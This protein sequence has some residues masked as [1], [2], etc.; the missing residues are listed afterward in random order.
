VCG[1]GRFGREVH[2]YLDYEGIRTTVIEPNPQ[3]APEGTIIGRGTEAVTLREADIDKAVGLVAGADQ[4]INN[5]S[6]IMTAKELKPDLFIVARQNRRAN[7]AIFKAAKLDLIMESS[8]ILVWRILPLLTNPLLSRF[9]LEARHRNEAWARELLQQLRGLCQG[10]TPQTWSIT[11]DPQQM[12]ALSAMLAQ[13]QSLLLRDLI[14]DPGARDQTLPCLALMRLRAD[15]ETLL[16][17][18]ESTLQSGDQ[19]LFCGA[20]QAYERQQRALDNPQLLAFLMTGQEQPDSYVWRWLS[21]QRK[22][23]VRTTGSIQ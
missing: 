15:K 19:I 18:P 23:S 5:L 10:R 21:Q 11:L 16:P 2:R 9:L 17:A 3:H 1:F 13:D 14:R 8:R 22:P 6:I 4:D 12:P 7:D 20:Q